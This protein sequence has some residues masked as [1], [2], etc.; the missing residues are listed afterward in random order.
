MIEEGNH[1]ITFTADNLLSANELKSLTS[2]IVP[3]KNKKVNNSKKKNMGDD[4]F[5]D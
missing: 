3:E 1:A 4:S 2:Q 5:L